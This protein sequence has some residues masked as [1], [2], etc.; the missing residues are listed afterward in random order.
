MPL[1]AVFFDIDG[2]LVASNEFHLM[3]WEE[4]F[5]DHS[6]PAP[7][8]NIRVQI[9]KGADQLIPS[10][11]AS[12]DNATQDRIAGRDGEVFSVR[13]LEKVRPL[14]HAADL[15]EMLHSEGKRVIL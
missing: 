5:H 12:I 9:R 10:L 8:D 1:K 2:T 15:V 13:Y 14:P 3:G 11:L 6:Q 4:A 7:K